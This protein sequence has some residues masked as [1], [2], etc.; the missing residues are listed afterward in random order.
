MLNAFAG[1][2]RKN[3]E[4]VLIVC[5]LLAILSKIVSLICIRFKHGEFTANVQ[6]S[7][8]TNNS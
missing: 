5:G 6:Y 4:I 7:K 3:L 2:T 1:T 8:T